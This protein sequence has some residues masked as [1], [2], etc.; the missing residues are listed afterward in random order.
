MGMDS[1]KKVQDVAIKGSNIADG[2][3]NPYGTGA[4]Q[5]VTSVQD[6]WYARLSRMGGTK[7]QYAK[8][9]NIPTIGAAT[10]VLTINVTPGYVGYITHLSLAAD[11]SGHF[12][13]GNTI[14]SDI[15]YADRKVFG[16]TAFDIKL[17][18]VFMTRDQFQVKFT[19]DVANTKTWASIIWLEV[20]E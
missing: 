14:G 11:N 6:N 9:I 10:G 15:Y 1:K 20:A 3:E 17:D 19:A 16:A 13:Y 12:Y 5:I 8:D 2:W 18:G 7:V 4:G